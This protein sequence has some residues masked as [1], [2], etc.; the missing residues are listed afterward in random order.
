MDDAG[1][2]GPIA[3]G[4]VANTSDLTFESANIL[5]TGSANDGHFDKYVSDIGDVNNDGFGD[6]ATGG[7]NSQGLCIFFGSQSETIAN[8]AIDVS[9]A[10]TG[11]GYQC[12]FDAPAIQGGF[13]ARNVGDVN[14]DGKQ[15]FAVPWGKKTEGAGSPG[16][17]RIAVYAGVSPGESISFTPILE[18]YGYQENSLTARFAGGGNFNGDTNGANPIHDIVVGAR[19]ANE[20]YVIPGATSWPAGSVDLSS[21]AEKGTFG[22][23]TITLVGVG[24]SVAPR[25][26]F[27]VGF[28]GNVLDDAGG[29]Q[30]DDIAIGA[31]FAGDWG[32]TQIS[33]I[34]G[35]ATPG[36]ET[37]VVSVDQAGP[38][39]G[40]PTPTEDG[41]A[42]TLK[43]E[44][45][46]AGGSKGHGENVTGAD[47][48]GDGI[49][50]IVATLAGNNDD[51]KGTFY[52]Y[53]G[54]AVRAAAGG[55][56]FI[57][58]GGTPTSIGTNCLE[59]PNGILLTGDGREFALAGNIN[60]DPDKPG[61][62][63]VW[64][65][66]ATTA[67][68]VYARLNTEDAASGRGYGTFAWIDHDLD[69]PTTP[70]S[71]S[72]GY[73]KVL[74]VGDF[75]GDGADDIIVG[76]DESGYATLLY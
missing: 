23:K 72:W 42:V 41:T 20:A 54:A 6:F 33:V 17:A 66:Y 37:L 7:F 49:P 22:V 35:R 57:S 34:K 64:R 43:P 5:I 55:T 26:G 18:I 61:S 46:G 63:L 19:N 9:M 16:Q 27:R 3:A 75:N 44:I 25:F 29:T 65:D 76:T 47:L 31:Q 51:T 67:G 73:F 56:I 24:T 28:V 45:N 69:D 30:Y 48:N 52:I 53:D 71:Q 21:A 11:A 58:G 70:G 38:D 2:A 50:E 1:N 36:A 14:G 4:S 60:G 12:H 40:D 8:F 10:P 13:P 59:G 68:G 39:G 32:K 15:D 74:G 62:D